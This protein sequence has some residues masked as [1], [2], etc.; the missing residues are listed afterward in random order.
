MLRVLTLQSSKVT[1][2]GGMKTCSSA[3]QIFSGYDDE[4]VTA[5]EIYSC[6]RQKEPTVVDAIFST[7]KGNATV[8]CFQMVSLDA[9]SL[10]S[11]L[12]VLTTRSLHRISTPL[13]L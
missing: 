11:Q 12:T 9:L 1:V 8:V 13:Y 4:C 10:N 3:I 7:E 5:G 2:S 6:G